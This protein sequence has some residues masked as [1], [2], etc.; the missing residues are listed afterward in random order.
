MIAV[1]F[2]DLS[3]FAVNA[4]GQVATLERRWGH[5]DLVRSAPGTSLSAE[6]AGGVKDELHVV[7][8][9]EDGVI[10]GTKGTV[11]ELYEGVSRATDAKTE[12]GETNYWRN[13]IEK[14]SNWIYATADT[15]GIVRPCRTS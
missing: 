2:T 4:N 3:S 6:G 8:E 1:E 14:S 13:V 12:S 5:W 7:V 10:T 9:D 15:A 11:L